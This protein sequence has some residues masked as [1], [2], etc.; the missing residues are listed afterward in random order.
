MEDD[1]DT[2]YNYSPTLEYFEESDQQ[3]KFFHFDK[4]STQVKLI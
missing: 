2:F 4:K 1:Q 3:T